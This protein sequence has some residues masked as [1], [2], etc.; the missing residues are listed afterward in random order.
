MRDVR[1]GISR[2]LKGLLPLCLLALPI[3]GF[4]QTPQERAQVETFLKEWKKTNLIIDSEFD[5]LKPLGKKALPLLAEYLSD[6]ELGTFAQWTMEKLDPVG[7]TPYLLKE[8]PKKDSNIQRQTFRFANR[9]MMEYDWYVRSGKPAADPTK[10]TPPYAGATEPYAYRKEIHDAAVQCL[11]AEANGGGETE[12]IKTVGLTGDRRDLPLLRKYAAKEGGSTWEG[13]F[14]A[15]SIAAM[16]RL[17]D[18]EALKAIMTE[19]EKPVPPH[20]AKPYVLDGSTPRKPIEPAPGAVVASPE[21]AQR[22]RNLAWQAGFSMDRRLI[23]YLLRHLDDPPAQFYG[24]YSD[25]SCARESMAALA[26]I[27]EGKE[28]GEQV[29]RSPEQW[30]QWGREHAKEFAK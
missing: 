11:K 7:A 9:R 8:L 12:A 10:P 30:K 13:S 1:F 6:K 22:M 15:L 21:D 14:H 16:A 19:L 29:Q 5:K 20:P 2:G 26:Q 17:G 27:A 24:D 18:A 28:Y 3:G 25:P 23:P 4:A